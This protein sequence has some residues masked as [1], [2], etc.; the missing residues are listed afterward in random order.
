[1]RFYEQLF[2][3]YVSGNRV[4]ANTVPR[5]RISLSAKTLENSKFQG[6][7]IF[8]NSKYKKVLSGNDND[9]FSH[10]FL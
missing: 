4:N 10:N 7:F 9:V 3:N 8:R 6:F 5:V 1:M 2:S